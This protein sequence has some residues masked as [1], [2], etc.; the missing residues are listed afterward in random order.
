MIQANELRIG[1][2]FS[3][4]SKHGVWTTAYDKVESIHEK[5]INIYADSDYGCSIIEPDF[6]FDYI[7]PIPITPE[8]LE[9]AGFE[10][11][12]DEYEIFDYVYLIHGMDKRFYL[13]FGIGEYPTETFIQYVHQLQNLYFA[14]TG[15]ELNIKL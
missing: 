11:S 9:K 2:W 6:T 5:G 1:N 13:W 12:I 7:Q 10:V 15:E 4:I 3:Y 8:I 14:L